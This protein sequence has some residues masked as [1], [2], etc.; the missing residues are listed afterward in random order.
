MNKKTLTRIFTL[1]VVL[2]L[3]LLLLQSNPL[4]ISQTNTQIITIKNDGSIDPSDAPI[5][6]DGNYYTLKSSISGG[7]TIQESH[8]VIDGAGYTIQGDGQIHG[9]TEILGM[10]LNFVDCQN[11]TVKNFNIKDFTRGIRFTNSSDCFVNQNILV[12]NHIGIE[13]GYVDNSYSNN[14]TVTGNFIEENIDAGIRL[15]HGNSNT[16]YGNIISANDQGISIWATSDNIIKLNN[17][18]D[19]NKA[20]YFETSGIN[21]IHHN[22]FVNNTNDWWDYGLTPWPFQLPFSFSIW[23]DGKEGNYWDEYNGTDLNRDG[24]GDVQLELY[25]DNIDRYPLI[26]IVTVPEP[27]I[28]DTQKNGTQDSFPLNMIAILTVIVAVS[29]VFVGGGIGLFFDRRK[30]KKRGN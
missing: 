22:N 2:L 19:N 17:I 28:V 24:V 26:N 18:T 14:N 30:R 16:I 15:I 25:E 5:Q 20:V 3:V 10:G 6:R 4:A 11:V 1:T 27:N 29:I 23:D 21:F 12:N 9:P 13:M 7:I 8:I